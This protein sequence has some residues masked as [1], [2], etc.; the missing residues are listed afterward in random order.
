MQLR[1]A[2]KCVLEH[3][4]SVDDTNGAI[5][6]SM[7]E[8]ISIEFDNGSHLIREECFDNIDVAVDVFLA[9]IQDD[10]NKVTVNW[11]KEGF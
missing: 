8:D 3:D 7:G 4:L 9:Y 1:D 5:Y 11:A 10:H 2:I 6:R